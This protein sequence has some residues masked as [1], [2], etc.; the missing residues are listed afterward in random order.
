MRVENDRLA[1]DHRD[2]AECG[3]GDIDVVI[4]RGG[5]YSAGI[6]QSG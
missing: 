6:R 1:D 3:N 2:P 4:L 5:K